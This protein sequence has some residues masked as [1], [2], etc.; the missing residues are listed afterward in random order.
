MT[1]AAAKDRGPQ[2]TR[3][4]GL[5]VAL[6]A[7]LLGSVIGCGACGGV[8]MAVAPDATFAAV[9]PLVC[10]GDSRVKYSSSH[11]SY[12]RPG[13]STPHIECVGRGRRADVTAVAVLTVLA[14]L[15]CCFFVLLAVPLGW[16][17]WVAPP[18]IL[19]AIRARTR[20]G[21]PR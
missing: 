19:A 6:L 2:V 14:A 9:G 13:Q 5:F 21:P 7:A 8:S 15:F 16:V 11:E 17:G 12:Q 3:A 1:T 18:R 20:W 4:A 10:S